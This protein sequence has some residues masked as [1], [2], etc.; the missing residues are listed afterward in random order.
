MQNLIILGEAQ[1][2]GKPI[3]I[4]ATRI[5]LVFIELTLMM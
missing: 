3:L 5:P 4:M 1:T 2:A